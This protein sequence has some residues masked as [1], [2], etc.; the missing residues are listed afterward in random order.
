MILQWFYGRNA[1]W[2]VP[3][4]ECLS[5][6]RRVLIPCSRFKLFES[7]INEMMIRGQLKQ[8]VIPQQKIDMEG[9]SCASTVFYHQEN[10]YR[11][12]YK[13]TTM[14]PLELC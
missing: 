14:C 7:M 10:R 4:L 5:L 6:R 8:L 2:S 13:Q 11:V 12:D 1:C 9:K 3:L